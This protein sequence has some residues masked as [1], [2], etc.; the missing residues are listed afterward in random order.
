MRP[1]SYLS[2]D[3]LSVGLCALIWGSTWF[4]ITAQLG[5]TPP[6]VA[7]LWRF[8][9]AAAVLGVLC[10]L[11]GRSLALP[12]AARRHTAGQ[13]ACTFA[14]SYAFVYMA[15]A[16]AP[17]ALVAVSFSALAFVNLCLFR[18][19]LGQRARRSAWIGSLCGVMG[20]AVL[21]LGQLAAAR[22]SPQFAQGLVLAILAVFVSALGNLFAHKAQEAGAEVMAN[23]AWSMGWGALF[24]AA[25]AA[26]FGQDWI[27]DPRP[28]F[29]I[30][31]LYLTLFGSVA[32][33][34]LYFGLARRRGFGFAS[35]VSAL[36]P[37]I[38][39]AIS[40]RFEGARWGVEAAAGLALIVAGQLLMTRPR[41][42]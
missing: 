24:L 11:T 18:L 12:P 13:G 41:A 4:A 17:S 20:V 36:T 29:W 10:R 6:L 35:Y 42:A 14:L 15:E 25:A 28:A 22:H 26:L 7:I 31:L 33:F 30:S 19:V 40:W 8:A 34:L 5:V 32:A 3:A 27:V 9:L 37:P 21:C 39:M 23:T 38:A 16:R 2:A 1:R